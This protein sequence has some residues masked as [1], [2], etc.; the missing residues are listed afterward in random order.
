M[1]SSSS[2]SSTA[3]RSEGVRSSGR[4]SGS[5]S[6]WSASHGRP[7]IGP[8]PR[9][10][11]VIGAQTPRSVEFTEAP[12]AEMEEKDI[13]SS[14]SASSSGS[15]LRR[16]CDG[17]SGDAHRYAVSASSNCGSCFEMLEHVPE[18][19]SHHRAETI[20][21]HG[22][23]TRHMPSMLP[24]RLGA[25][26]GETACCDIRS[27]CSSPA[28]A[29]SVTAGGTGGSSR[30]SSSC[31]SPAASSLLTTPKRVDGTF[32][33]AHSSAAPPPGSGAPF[34]NDSLDTLSTAQMEAALQ[35]YVEKG[36]VYTNE[37][38][39]ALQA[40][41]WCAATSVHASPV[42]RVADPSAEDTDEEAAQHLVDPEVWLG[43]VA[44]ATA[45]A[46]AV[47]ENDEQASVAAA[48]AATRIA[49]AEALHKTQGQHSTF[50]E[51]STMLMQ[52]SNIAD[53]SAPVPVERT[54]EK[55][56]S[57]ADSSSELAAAGGAAA[58]S[59]FADH[60][61]RCGPGRS[62]AVVS[63][64]DSRFHLRGNCSDDS[65]PR[66]NGVK[67]H[68]ISTDRKLAYGDAND[69]ST[70]RAARGERSP[71]FPQLTPRH[72]SG[73]A[74]Q[75]RQP[76]P[77]FVSNTRSLRSSPLYSSVSPMQRSV[78]DQHRS[79]ATAAAS[80]PAYVAED[81]T[82]IAAPPAASAFDA[83]FS[84]TAGMHT[85]FQLCL[86]TPLATASATMRVSDWY[87]LLDQLRHDGRHKLPPQP[88][89][90]DVARTI[91][92]SMQSEGHSGGLTSSDFTRVIQRQLKEVKVDMT[93]P[94]PRNGSAGDGTASRQEVALHFPQ[95]PRYTVTVPTSAA[96]SSQSPSFPSRRSSRRSSQTK[97][98]P[99]TEGGQWRVLPTWCMAL[100][101][102]FPLE[103]SKVCPVPVVRYLRSVGLIRAVLEAII[104]RLQ[105]EVEAIPECVASIS[106][107]ASKEA[108]NP[109]EG[110]AVESL[111]LS[112]SREGSGGSRSVSNLLAR[113]GVSAGARPAS[114]TVVTEKAVG[115]SGDRSGTWNEQPNWG[116]A[117]A[118]NHRRRVKCRKRGAAT[119]IV[120]TPE[121]AG[122]DGAMI[123]SNPQGVS[124][125]SS[126]PK[127]DT[128]ASAGSDTFK[129]H[130]LDQRP[131]DEISISVV[132][133]AKARRLMD[134]LRRHTVPINRYECFA[135]VEQEDAPV[136]QALC[137][138]S[139]EELKATLSSDNGEDSDED[140]DAMS[141]MIAALTYSPGE[142][143]VASLVG[144]AT[145][146][147][148]G[149]DVDQ[150]RSPLPPPPP[151]SS[152]S[153]PNVLPTVIMGATRASMHVGGRVSSVPTSRAASAG[154]ALRPPPPAPCMFR[155]S[156]VLP[157][158]LPRKQE[159]A[160][161]S[162]LSKPVCDPAA[163]SLR[164]ASAE[165]GYTSCHAADTTTTID[166]SDSASA[167]A[168]AIE[169]RPTRLTPSRLPSGTAAQRH[170]RSRLHPTD[171]ELSNDTVSRS[172][173][174]APLRNGFRRRRGR[175]SLSRMDRC[176]AS[177][178][179]GRQHQ[180]SS[181]LASDTGSGGA[182]TS[183]PAEGRNRSFSFFDVPHVLAAAPLSSSAAAAAAAQVIGDGAPSAS[184][185]GV[186]VP[187]QPPAPR[188]QAGHH[189]ASRG[190][191]RGTSR[192]GS[193]A[194]PR[195]KAKDESAEGRRAG[196]TPNSA[197]LKLARRG[198]RSRR[199]TPRC[200]SD[201]PPRDRSAADARG[202]ENSSRP[203]AA[204]AAGAA[205][206]PAAPL[207]PHISLYERR[208]CRQL[209][210]AYS[211]E[212]IYHRTN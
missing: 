203:K 163:M 92:H 75:Q 17:D 24:P 119:N 35:L 147:G 131:L 18:N 1:P 186:A 58:Y 167:N 79:P 165:N 185:S 115:S 111:V 72:R 4:L 122:G 60:G 44:A 114:S 96:V 134:T 164:V 117:T 22:T 95:H 85:L 110:A 50:E 82:Q 68:H 191:P 184:S 195:A 178:C 91:A 176:Y 104:Q 193:A 208:L 172:G 67:G 61:T 64:V 28:P 33:G 170:Y 204:D 209:Q 11:R 197:V 168:K 171:R 199:S 81:A 13:Y 190:A 76:V 192:A 116:S 159:E 151:L 198:L 123:A 148:S 42:S 45:S 145:K 93:S 158:A 39:S 130:Y 201:A 80:S 32:A 101:G 100:A 19:D 162:R 188:R 200:S 175:L 65:T 29:A 90:D 150:T 5:H 34:S 154:S 73:S 155:M 146:D 52:P 74:Q 143:A 129:S 181:L 86:R 12:H 102:L 160:M 166:T 173:P 207:Q 133:R 189:V 180:P 211:N 127:A 107:A 14:S 105:I 187:P 153:A 206:P 78:D 57:S 125:G 109:S 94:L 23:V 149:V 152:T 142:E 56:R 9:G 27:T 140:S 41:P 77:S 49:S 62:S 37:M 138:V 8:P 55:Q 174:V 108:Q 157:T 212:H 20:V 194:P 126:R 21:A 113:S 98:T 70:E 182:C 47:A 112:P 136:Q 30:P 59:D 69:D 89:L 25:R 16:P 97:L 135:R 63:P 156:G 161:V 137:F 169:D 2:S 6:S 3:H 71:S 120:A 15:R 183:Q 205:H 144:T 210:R 106:S 99:V 128:T 54:V 83:V 88:I 38:T 10:D 51:G 53:S 139:R 87:A 103:M 48:S 132:A 36:G 26:V 177:V 118:G 121:R 31:P 46:V 7:T 84:G 179:P 202:V 40:L 66:A 124:S 43:A 196:N 141:D